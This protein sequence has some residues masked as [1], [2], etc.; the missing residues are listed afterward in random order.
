MRTAA[1][2]RRPRVAPGGCSVQPPLPSPPFSH[3][4]PE[5]RPGTRKV[6]ENEKGGGQRPA[7]G[8][9]CFLLLFSPV[10]WKNLKWATPPRVL[11]SGHRERAPRIAA[12][13]T[14][15]PHVA[16]GRSRAAGPRCPSPWVRSGGWCLQ[17]CYLHYPRL[18]VTENAHEC[19]WTCP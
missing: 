7:R 11:A 19:G 2:A 10:V 5:A 14:C 9:P 1:A 16:S 18:P 6:P 15:S 3:P 4:H 8:G 17:T 13:T 12:A